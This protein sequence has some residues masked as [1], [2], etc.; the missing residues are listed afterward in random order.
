MALKSYQE[1]RN[2]QKTSEPKGKKKITG[3]FRFVVQ[4]HQAQ[5]LHYDFRIEHDGV[6]VSWAVP[7]GVPTSSKEKHLAMHVEDHPLEYLNFED[8]IPEGEYGAGTVMV[9]DKGSYT[10]PKTESR[11][12]FS[13]RITAGLDKGEIKLFLKGKKLKG[14]FVLVRFKRAGEKAWLF[15]K[16]K[17]YYNNFKVDNEH[18]AKSGLTMEEIT[19]KFGDNNKKVQKNSGINSKQRTKISSRNAVGYKMPEIIKPM[20]A[21]LKDEPFNNKNWLFEPKFDGYR[22]LAFIENGKVR[23][24]SRNSLLLNEKYPEIVTALESYKFNFKAI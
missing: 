3:K 5:Q 8:T 20:L 7:K 9:W 19:R 1:K 10:V 6:L 15:I 24:F 11:V 22:V 17:D 18:S 23:L 14:L 16:D 13:D 2:F 4:K 12:E 21:T